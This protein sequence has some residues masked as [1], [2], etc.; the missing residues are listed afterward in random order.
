MPRSAKQTYPG[1]IWRCSAPKDS[2]S[3]VNNTITGNG[4]Y[5]ITLQAQ[6]LGRLSG[7]GSVAGNTK[8]GIL[9]D[10]GEVDEDG[11]W[12]KHDAPYIVSGR[13]DIRSETGV[14]M[15]IRPGESMKNTKSELL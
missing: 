15:T 7:V 1:A 4:E 2:A 10:G 11:V 6:S 9:I 3:F 14:S 5:G 8:G 13:V 12:K